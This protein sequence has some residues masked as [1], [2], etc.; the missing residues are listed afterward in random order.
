MVST[1]LEYHE[2]KLQLY[3]ALKQEEKEKEKG[4]RGKLNRISTNGSPYN[5]VGNTYCVHCL[6]SHTS[7]FSHSVIRSCNLVS[8]GRMK[9]PS[10]NGR[11]RD[12]LILLC[13]GSPEENRPL[14]R[15]RSKW[16]DDIQMDLGDR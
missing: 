8:S 9:L 3:A 4:K 13:L 2:S 15:P 11:C 6:I 10:R 7:L 12:F 14:E 16:K 5:A 1:P